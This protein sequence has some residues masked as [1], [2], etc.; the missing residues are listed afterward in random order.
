MKLGLCQMNIAWE[1]KTEN[2]KK[3]ERYVQIASE[4]GVELILFPE[5]C[6]TGFSMNI[7]KTM[8]YEN[9]SITY[10]THISKRFGIHIGFGWTKA[11]GTGETAQNHYT[12]INQHGE[13]CSDYCKI[14]P[15]SYAREDH[16]FEAGTELVHVELN[17]FKLSTFIC[18]DLRFPE[19]FQAVSENVQLIIVAANWPR[20]RREHWNC[21]I[22]ARAIENQVFIAAVNCVGMVGT[23]DY[24]GDSCIIDPYGTILSELSN[25]EGILVCDI[26]NCV[27]KYRQEFPVKQD[28]KIQLYAKLLEEY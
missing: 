17:E 10:F 9:E 28:R 21:L 18:Y 19:I 16:F 13:I 14:H 20:Q 6:L 1:D 24:S 5:M 22:R 3:V 7:Q 15:F 11:A 27:D 26:E 2:K 12:I 8:E 23:Q 25:Q 4:Q